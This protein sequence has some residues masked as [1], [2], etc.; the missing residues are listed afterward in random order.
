MYKATLQNSAC[1][2]LFLY[3]SDWDFLDLNLSLNGQ[4]PRLGDR[5]C[6]EVGFQRRC[7]SDGPLTSELLKSPPVMIFAWNDAVSFHCLLNLQSP[8]STWPLT[9]AG[10]MND[11]RVSRRWGTIG[12]VRCH[13]M[14]EWHGQR[15][16]S[17]C[18]CWGWHLAWCMSRVK[19]LVFDQ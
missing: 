18:H 6:S 11:D 9:A 12:E 4:L 15:T 14:S 13:L 1:S 16:G 17:G 5:H 10:Q 7:A 8:F 19:V 3:V 2:H